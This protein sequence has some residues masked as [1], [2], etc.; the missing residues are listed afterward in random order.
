VLDRAASPTDKEHGHDRSRQRARP[1][2]VTRLPAEDIRRLDPYGFLA[3]LGKRVIRPG[4]R[5]ST[6]QLPHRPQGHARPIQASK[7]W[8]LER[9][10]AWGNAFGKP[11]WCTE[12]R[13]RVVGFSLALA[14]ASSSWVGWSAARGPDTAGRPAQAGARNRPGCQRCCSDAA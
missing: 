4:G 12:R 9:T 13:R 14:H 5:R 10:H 8:P 7:R 6:H 2:A 11:R 1:P 3:V